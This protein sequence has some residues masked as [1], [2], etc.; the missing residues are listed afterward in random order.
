MSVDGPAPEHQDPGGSGGL[1]DEELARNMMA[2]DDGLHRIQDKFH[3]HVMFDYEDPLA[4]GGGNFVFYPE[5]DFSRRFVIEERFTGTDWSDEDR[6]PTS[7]TW[8]SEVTG[9]RPD[10]TYRWVNNAAGKIPSARYGDLLRLAE[11]WAQ[12]EHDLTLRE[13]ALTADPV[14][15]SRIAGDRIG[16]SSLT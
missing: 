6:L 16:R 10:G 15:T 12:T 9:R 11:N 8:A 3:E 13:D 7:W 4:F 14:G 2:L 1:S 5:E